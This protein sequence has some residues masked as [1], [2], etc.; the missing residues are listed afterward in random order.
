M[1]R[2]ALLLL[3]VLPTISP[4]DSTHPLLIVPGGRGH[5]KRDGWPIDNI[6]NAEDA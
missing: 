6:G 5:A 3:A 1:N 2:Y 4:F